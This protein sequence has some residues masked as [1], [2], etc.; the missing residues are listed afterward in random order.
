MSGFSR[1]VK[2]IERV[3][4]GGWCRRDGLSCFVVERRQAPETTH[5]RDRVATIAA[6]LADAAGEAPLVMGGAPARPPFVFFDLETTG[7]SG[8]AGTY[9]FLVGC[10]AFDA[11][12]A[13]VTRQFVL[14]RH[15]D[16]RQLLQMVGAE[17][18]QAGALVTFNGKSFD[19]PLIEMRYLFHRLEW[20][21]GALPHLDVLHPARRFWSDGGAGDT[22]CSLQALE[23][24]VLGARRTGD[25]PG[26]EIPTRY[27]R[28]IHTGDARPLRAV[29]EHNRL[30]L[31]SLA[32]LT[33]R[34]LDLVRR[35]PGAARHAR[36]AL[37]LGRVYA[38][39]GLDSRAREAYQHACTE[40]SMACSEA[41]M[42]CTEA[43][44]ASIKI[45]GLRSLA[46][47]SRRSRQYD[48]AAAYWRELLELP[49]CPSPVAR[50]ASQALAVHHE[51]R[52]RDLPAAR[53]FAL[54]SFD[55]HKPARNQAV[56][57]RLARIE[58]K[59]SERLKLFPS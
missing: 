51:H 5:G 37:A 12:G 36:E 59:I 17:I 1:T 14:L 43:S 6:R 56:R 42:A 24:A 52:A 55:A 38:R 28:F 39:G 34:L 26:S 46:L 20:T 41:S 33:A 8:G 10:G 4:G 9:A 58:R 30:D 11:D 45:D 40:A 48:E 57:Y 25:V 19:A 23:N 2:E 21:G 50:E 15:A 54:R 53:A 13:F 16:E 29:L 44:M 27:F 32:G 35:G 3:L 18:T 49:A 22:P 31:L 7:L 47:L